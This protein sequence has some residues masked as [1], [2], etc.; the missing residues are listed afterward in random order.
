MQ[1]LL[2]P[3][4]FDRLEICQMVFHSS[5]AYA[6]NFG[7]QMLH[8]L[9]VR[10]PTSATCVDLDIAENTIRSTN[11]LPSGFETKNAVKRTSFHR[12]E[13]GIKIFHGSP[14]CAANLPPIATT[15][16]LFYP[17][18]RHSSCQAS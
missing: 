2:K 10:A 15:L 16:R 18:V 8:W 6:A 9:D 7:N 5:P 12:L 11:A 3:T 1:A 13:I 17:A 14:A 4:S